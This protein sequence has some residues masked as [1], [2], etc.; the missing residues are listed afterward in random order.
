MYYGQCSLLSFIVFSL[1]QRKY[2]IGIFTT[3]YLLSEG[4][5]MLSMSFPK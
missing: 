3:I 2:S 4:P 1:F 5:F